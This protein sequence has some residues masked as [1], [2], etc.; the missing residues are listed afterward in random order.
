MN[1]SDYPGDNE[2]ERAL[3]AF[4]DVADEVIFEGSEQ[5]IPEMVKRYIA[6]R[7]ALASEA[8][9]KLRRYVDEHGGIEA[10]FGETK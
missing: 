6:L 1:P 7:S 5:H 3:N 9:G 2:A 4:I 8:I 10:V